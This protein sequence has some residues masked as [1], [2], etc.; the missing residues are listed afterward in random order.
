MN[1]ILASE[2]PAVPDA[3]RARLTAAYSRDETEAVNEL[4]AQA[5]LPPAERDLVLARATELVARVRAKKIF[6]PTG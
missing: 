2:L 3:A 1:A 6:I 4:I 5:E